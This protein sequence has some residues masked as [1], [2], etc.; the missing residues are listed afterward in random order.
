MSTVALSTGVLDK[1]RAAFLKQ[2]R[3]R[4]MSMGVTRV[5][6]DSGKVTTEVDDYSGC[7]LELVE[8]R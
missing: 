2:A 8:S 7:F 3:A 6:V 5:D 4:E 1:W